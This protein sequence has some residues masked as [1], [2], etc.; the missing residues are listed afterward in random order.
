[1]ATVI[2]ACS[3]LSLAV[4]IGIMIVILLYF[5]R[6]GVLMCLCVLCVSEGGCV[7]MPKIIDV[8]LAGCIMFGK[9]NVRR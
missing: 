2:I 1:M 5:E 9:I 3:A 4:S 8:Q 6:D 7:G